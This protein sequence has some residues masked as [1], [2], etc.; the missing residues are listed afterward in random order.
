[1]GR[2]QSLRPIVISK[3]H[4]SVA[5][6]AGALWLRVL[7]WLCFIGL[8]AAQPLS[9]VRG[10]Q[11]L[12]PRCH[13]ARKSPLFVGFAAGTGL[14]SF[15]GCARASGQILRRIE[16]WS[17]EDPSSVYLAMPSLQLALGSEEGVSVE[18]VH[19][20]APDQS[21]AHVLVSHGQPTGAAMHWRIDV[22][23]LGD[24]WSVAQVSSDVASSRA[25]P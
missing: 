23:R 14:E 15:E 22:E 3:T 13:V 24:S 1:M 20:D 9:H 7:G 11:M 16:T 8:A 12:A 19:F 4:A 17:C 25:L 6:A 5:P 10:E 2:A 18:S 21:L